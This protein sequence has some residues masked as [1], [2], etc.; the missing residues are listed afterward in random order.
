VKL[1]NGTVSGLYTTHSSHV[2]QIFF[3]QDL[4]TEVELVSPYKENT[5]QLT[6]NENDGI[7]KEEAADIDPFME[8]VL[9]GDSVSDGIFAWISMAIDP[10]TDRELSP[11][12]YWT[13]EGGIVNPKSGPGGPGGPPSGSAPSGP[14]PNSSA[15]PSG[16]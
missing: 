4:I 12:A 2:G 13:K 5:Q 6:L 3:D 1:A 11:A 15:V 16:L 10:T 9:L 7:L 14:A 8:Y